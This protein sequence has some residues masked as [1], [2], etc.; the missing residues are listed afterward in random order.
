MTTRDQHSN[1][2][3]QLVV[4][5]GTKSA[6]VT[7]SAVDTQGYES[8]EFLTS[9]GAAGDTLSG[10][11]LFT[12]KLQDSPDGST[13]TDVSSTYLL[14]SPAVIN[15]PS[16]NSTVQSVGYVGSARYVRT[17]LTATGTMSSGTPIAV[18]AIL[19]HPHIRPVV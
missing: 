13:W 7:S 11:V 4:A 5:P 16:F 12:Q 8:V 1:I 10:T 14:G 2:K 3:P 19:G 17:V 15:A 6:T 18:N 9:I